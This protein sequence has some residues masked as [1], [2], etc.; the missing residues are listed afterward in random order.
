MKTWSCLALALIATMALVPAL[1][2]GPAAITQEKVP[3]P[4]RVLF[5]GNSQIYFNDLPQMVEAVSESAPAD[6]PRIRA[7]R[8]VAGGASLERHW[9]RGTGKDTPRAKIAEQKWD[10]VILQEIYYAKPENFTKHARLFHELIRQNGAQTVLFSTASIS[11]L[12]PKGFQELHDM[13]IALGKEL[14][15][16]VAAAG[17]AW[18]TYWGDTPS[19]EE[20]LGLYDADKAHPGQKGSYIY[21]CALYAVLTGH[22]PVG[23]TNRIPKQPEGTITT[24]EA[25]RMQEAAWRVHGEVNRKAAVQK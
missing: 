10:Y 23:L 9:N 19:A 1:V 4:I 11:T 17:N 6:R 15:S 14:K 18:L 7:D 12:Y 3:Q 2:P 22:S 5:V 16:P 25:K 24:E 20:R 8:A 21:A 13:H